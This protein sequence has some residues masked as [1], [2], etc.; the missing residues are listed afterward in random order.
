VGEAAL[1]A[2]IVEWNSGD[3][4]GKCV[5]SLPAAAGRVP[6]RLV[7]VANSPLQAFEAPEGIA[8]DILRNPVN[9]GFAA[10]ANQGAGKGKADLILFLNPDMQLFPHAIEDAV[11]FLMRP[12]HED[13]ATV[14]IQ[15]VDDAGSIARTCAR[16]PTLWNLTAETLGLGRLLPGLVRGLFL[17][18]WDHR[19][20][21]QVDHVIGAFFLVRRSV[22]T[23]LGGFDERFFVYLE[24]LDFSC[25][26]A[27]TGWRTFYVVEARAHHRGGGT[28]AQIP[29]RRLFYAVRSRIQLAFKHLGSAGGAVILIEALV[30]E[31]VVRLLWSVGRLSAVDAK[32]T[33]QAATMLWRD[34][35]S[36]RLK[37]QEE[38]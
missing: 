2:V 36:G 4:L 32:A 25:R 15:L 12:G 9:R 35:V 37:V 19:T 18:E 30:L 8:P 29:G 7:V 14:G 33:A 23:T 27:R 13:V 28:S 11:A 5:A 34:V 10:A 20:T 38:S 31:P 21:R 6:V 17:R 3:Q 22:F 24:D 26:A 16:L 1:D